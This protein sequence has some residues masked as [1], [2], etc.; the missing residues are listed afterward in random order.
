[1]DSAPLAP[2]PEYDERRRMAARLWMTWPWLL[3]LTL[4]SLPVLHQLEISG[5]GLVLCPALGGLLL[6][7]VV[8]LQAR[9]PRQGRVEA[10]ASTEAAPSPVPS[11][12]A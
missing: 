6:T 4:A 1:M 10:V 3:V 12:A 8:V 11:P 5:L 2:L 9:R 7:F